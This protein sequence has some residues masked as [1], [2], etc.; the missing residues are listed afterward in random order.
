M[1]ASKWAK[2]ENNKERK[3]NTFLKKRPYGETLSISIDRLQFNAVD[4][5][6]QSSLLFVAVSKQEKR[7]L[8]LNYDPSSPER[9][10]HFKHQHNKVG[11]MTFP[12]GK[13]PN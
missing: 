10:W 4:L 5:P 3:E 2:F 7:P 9:P 13:T 11:R 1:N 6:S 8:S 12:T